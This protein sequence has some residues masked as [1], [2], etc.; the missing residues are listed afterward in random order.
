MSDWYRKNLCGAP[1][2]LYCPICGQLEDMHPPPPMWPKTP[3]IDN[4][5]EQTP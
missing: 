5:P 2:V 1:P 3:P 4:P